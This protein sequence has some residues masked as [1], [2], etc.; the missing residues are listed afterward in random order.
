MATTYSLPKKVTAP[1]AG[2]VNL[3]QMSSWQLRR[4]REQRWR[5][6]TDLVFLANEVL[7]YP[8]VSRQIH[9]FVDILQKFPSPTP[10]QFV[11]NDKIVSYQPILP[12]YS[13]P[14]ALHG[15]RKVLILDPRGFLKSTCNVM[16]HA[17]QW[18]LNY[19]DISML[20]T[21]ATS[22]NAEAILDE[23]TRHFLY[24]E[25]FRSLFP[26]HAPVKKKQLL[27]FTKAALTTPAR[28]PHALSA[29]VSILTGSI[30]KGLTGHHFDV[31]KFSDIVYP[32]NSR[33]I[34][35]IRSVIDTFAMM[36][37]L[38]VR[39]DSWI[40]VE[41]T[42][43]HHSDLYTRIMESEMERGLDERE[44]KIHVR[45]CFVKDTGDQPQR[46]VPEEVRLPDKK[47]AEGKRIS[48]WPGRFPTDKLE[49]IERDPIFGGKTFATQQLLNPKLAM[50]AP[51]FPVDE[52]YPK[53]I[54]REAFS[55]VPKSHYD[56]AV[57]TAETQGGRSN[58]TSMAVG[59]WDTYNRCYVV[60]I[61]HGKLTP[62]QI[63]AQLF[64][65][66]AKYKPRTIKIEKTAF[67]RGLEHSIKREM[68]LVG[69]MLPYELIPRD[70]QLSK[71]ERITNT[72][73]PPYKSG[74]LRFLDDL[75]PWKH[76]VK[77]LE[78]FPDYEFDDILDSLADL[79]QNKDWMGRQSAKGLY[80][81]KAEHQALVNQIMQ[82]ELEHRLGIQN[83]L[84][85]LTDRYDSSW[86]E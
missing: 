21:Q 23:I 17:I 22:P 7:D 25:K 12:L 18:L 37:N 31:L 32:E 1:R 62:G 77:E 47:D 28:S 36:R 82:K 69:I 41:G 5:A 6:R 9:V 85:D 65:L 54:S 8:D 43:Y 79:F 64:R 13:L 2:W 60:E 40:D 80:T 15:S 16:T 81:S 67:V 45:P 51:T 55:R 34:G 71:V 53:K 4:F 72:L 49:A 14:G 83:D 20:I 78:N 74:E 52:N 58:Y 57:D 66:N 27:S 44:W 56:V 68:D 63:I 10:D 59:C 48:W 19:P 70:T 26:E 24:N 39:P 46:F 3:H 33:T 75:T 84:A 73:Q 86:I 76:L 35:Q 11:Q 30:E 50:G 61:V 42:I 38:T 29:E